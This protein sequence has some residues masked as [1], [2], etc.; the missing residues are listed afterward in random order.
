MRIHYTLDDSPARLPL[1]I[2]SSEG[3]MDRAADLRNAPGVQLVELTTQHMLNTGTTL[4]DELTDYFDNGGP[5]ES[6]PYGLALC[7]ANR[8]A[9]TDLLRDLRDLPTGLVAF[10]EVEALFPV[11][12]MRELQFTLALTSV[13]FPAFGYVRAFK[14]SEGEEYYG[15]VVNLA[16][17]QPHLEASLGTYSVDLLVNMIRHGFFNHQGFLLAYSEY[18]ESIGR[19]PEKL[20]DRLKDKLMARGIAWYLSYRHDIP[21]YDDV[22]RLDE[23]MIGEHIAHW[24]KLID[25]SH[26]KGQGEDI[27]D[28]WLARPDADGFTGELSLDVVGYLAART[29]AAEH[30]NKGLRDS[31]T[32]GGDYFLKLYNDLAGN[33]LKG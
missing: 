5:S 21:F 15:L 16:Q 13:G 18:C 19:K 25:S 27:L 31:V 14:D 4:V 8:E 23:T 22:L 26:K 7:Y 10:A 11:T 20:H 30:G 12:F 33:K 9:L 29:I 32:K 24:N 2:R 3:A 17:A 6:D 1:A 28:E